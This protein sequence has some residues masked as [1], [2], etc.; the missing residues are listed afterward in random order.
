MSEVAGNP[1]PDPWVKFVKRAV[2][3]M[4]DQDYIVERVE[5]S[6][7]TDQIVLILSPVAK[8]KER[9]KR[10]FILSNRPNRPWPYWYEVGL[11]YGGL[12]RNRPKYWWRDMFLIPVQ[13]LLSQQAERKLYKV[14]PFDV[15]REVLRESMEDYP[16]QHEGP[17]T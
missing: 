8:V 3:K 6:Q 15:L 17:W 9:Q 12:F 1:I 4:K 7:S 16:G 5:V 10:W 14:I 11:E 13:T 2:R